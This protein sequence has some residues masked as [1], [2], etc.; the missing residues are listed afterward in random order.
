LGQRYGNGVAVDINAVLDEFQQKF[1]A[2]L[3]A[4]I[5]RTL[6]VTCNK[7]GERNHGSNFIGNTVVL[8][9]IEATSQFINPHSQ[10]ELNRFR[11]EAEK[12]YECL[13][14]EPKQYLIPRHSKTDGSQLAK[15][16]MKQ[17]F[18]AWFSERKEFGVPLGELVWAFRNPHAH[19]FYPHY[20]KRF[21]DKLI[22]GAVDWLYKN[23]NQRIGIAISEI[24]GDFDSFKCRL[25]R[26]EGNCFRVCPQILFVFFKRALTE[27]INRVRSDNETQT[28]FL[29]SY[30]RLSGVYGFEVKQA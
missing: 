3:T 24:E 14:S 5:T 16:F 23:R 28:Q 21:N 17:Y 2:P 13:E 27:F 12:Q 11:E 25:Y 18:D 26:I 4:D 22:S 19:S 20:Q 7:S 1:V 8:M 15:Q 10:E 29:E 9:G 6:E 30:N